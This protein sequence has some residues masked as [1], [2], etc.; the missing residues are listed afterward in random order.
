MDVASAKTALA[1]RSGQTGD[2]SD[3]KNGG[4]SSGGGGSGD[5]E[6]VAAPSLLLG[7][8]TKSSEGT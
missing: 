7:I 8:P 3:M 2:S 4:G 5:H 1:V 6:N